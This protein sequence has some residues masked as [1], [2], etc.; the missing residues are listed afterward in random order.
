MNKFSFKAS[1]MALTLGLTIGAQSTVFA[2]T[3]F[4][5]SNFIKNTVTATQQ[6]KQTAQQIAIYGEEV[7]QYQSM[8][9][10][11]KQLNPA[12]I[13]QGVSRGFIPPGNYSSPSQVANAAQGVYGSYQQI[14]T[15]MNGF[16]TSYS[17]INKV[18]QGLDT[19]SIA[20]HVSPD[21]ILQYDFQRSQQGV[22]QDTNYYT[23]LQNL[24]GQL[25]QHQ[26]RADSLAAS[27]P[28]QNGTVQL[29][30]TL[31]AQNTVLQDQLTHLI[32]VN[33]ITANK[34]IENSLSQEAKNQLEARQ[35][36]AGSQTEKN[37][38]K[39]FTK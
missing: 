37:A 36:S 30:Q 39:Y 20:S 19:T 1:L 21:K 14:G 25:A 18:M 11:L 35:L 15:T 28:A 5:P 32:Q 31:G 17:G 8:V 16:N 6:V 4:D 2:M 22:T 9:Q 23:Q 29:L 13:Q 26:Q 34:T 27:L 3:V 7:K 33:T 24:N 12:I 10:N 38:Q